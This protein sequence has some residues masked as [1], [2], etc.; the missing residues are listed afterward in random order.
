MKNKAVAIFLLIFCLSLLGVGC[1]KP[2]NQ[3]LGEV[4]VE[5]DITSQL[6]NSALVRTVKDLGWKSI[7]DKEVTNGWAKGG[8]K[9]GAS[10]EEVLTDTHI[11]VYQGINSEEWQNREQEI[12]KQNK[13]PILMV[14]TKFGDVCCTEQWGLYAFFEENWAVV[15]DDKDDDSQCSKATKIIN[16]YFDNLKKAE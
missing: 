15:V 9:W 6:V 10:P 14:K 4:V 8:H 13:M 16:I 1:K 12:C 7:W 3:E 11:T 2:N 5:K